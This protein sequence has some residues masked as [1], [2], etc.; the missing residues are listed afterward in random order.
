MDITDAKNG[1]GV[2]QV[3]AAYTKS[4]PLEV[5]CPTGV[6]GGEIGGGRLARLG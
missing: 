1:H 5:G 6:A 4:P 3:V 2:Y